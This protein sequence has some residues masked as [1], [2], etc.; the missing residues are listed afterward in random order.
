MTII[1]L[2]DQLLHVIQP[3]FL[4]STEQYGLC[5]GQLKGKKLHV[6]KLWR[7][8]MIFLFKH[9]VVLAQQPAVT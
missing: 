8:S 9:G 3:Q 4:I 5:S 7:V 1:T 6:S 2:L